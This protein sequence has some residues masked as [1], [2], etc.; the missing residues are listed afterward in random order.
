MST[1]EDPPTVEPVASALSPIQ[2]VVDRPDSEPLDRPIGGSASSPLGEVVDIINGTLST[3]QHQVKR[4]G[5]TTVDQGIPGSK[6]GKKRKIDRSASVPYIISK[7]RVVEGKLVRPTPQLVAREDIGSKSRDLWDVPDHTPEPVHIRFEAERA[8][9]RQTKNPPIE[10]LVDPAPNVNNTNSELAASSPK[11]NPKKVGRP[12]KNPKLHAE[13]ISEGSG[14]T[15]RSQKADGVTSLDPNHKLPPPKTRRVKSNAVDFDSEINEEEADEQPEVQAVASVNNVSWENK[16]LPPNETV[17][18]RARPV[19]QQLPPGK[20]AHRKTRRAEPPDIIVNPEIEDGDAN[21]QP[22]I[23]EEATDKDPASKN[24]YLPASEAID[25]EDTRSSPLRVPG[26]T[27]QDG[28]EEPPSRN[29]P[30]RDHIRAG[31]GD[32]TPESDYGHDKSSQTAQSPEPDLQESDIVLFGQE[33]AWQKILNAKRKIGVSSIKGHKI[34][35][36]PVLKTRKIKRLVERSED[37]VRSYESLSSEATASEEVMDQHQKY[38]RGIR[39]NIANL[40]SET[41]PNGDKA[42]KLIRDI[43]A[44]AVPSMVTLLKKAL[45][46]RS[47][48][49][50]IGNEV[51]VLQ[52]IISIQDALFTLCKTAR[53]WKT[54]PEKGRP[55]TQPTITIK[56]CIEAVR[57]AFNAELDKRRTHIKRRENEARRLI[58]EEEEERAQQEQSE[59]RRREKDARDRREWEEVS[60]KCAGLPGFSKFSSQ[61]QSKKGAEYRRL[62]AP[63][64]NEWS[65]EQDCELLKELLAEEHGELPAEERYLRALNAPSLKNMLPMHIKER[66]L[67]Y[68]EAMEKV[69]KEQDRQIPQWL[70]NM[71]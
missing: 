44:H 28:A 32:S 30:K 5:E 53:G 71:E 19:S 1:T 25:D 38:L 23:N 31:P 34:R 61:A 26:N 22:N 55:I 49:L 65:R 29:R 57:A 20:P 8:K 17:G 10:S 12:R 11:K 36:I 4:K 43:Y 9:S 16:E 60:R 35:K 7:S 15:L 24:Q 68:K 48:V 27:H 41:M 59:V 33:K 47:P 70:L 63:G 67:G 58:E 56:N 37:A 3:N 45:E 14:R 6:P 54:K 52:E 50:A 51:T 2:E 66:A 64:V 13:T 46:T 69:L 18:S 21:E 62:K 39:K 40:P 42:S